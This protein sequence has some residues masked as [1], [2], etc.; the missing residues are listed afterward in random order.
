M[1]L[2]GI[3]VLDAYDENIIHIIIIF[4]FALEYFWNNYLINWWHVPGGWLVYV[5]NI[6]NS[7]L[8]CENEENNFVGVWPIYL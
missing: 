5:A 4:I 2:I 3:L 8:I 7:F 1:F 6:F